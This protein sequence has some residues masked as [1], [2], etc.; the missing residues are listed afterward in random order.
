MKNFDQIREDIEAFKA[1]DKS[2]FAT[3]SFQTH[4][5]PLLHI[6]S[7]IDKNI[8]IF[9]LNT[10]YLFPATIAFKDRLSEDLGL[11]FI[12]LESAI[13]KSQ[14]KDSNGQLLF[15]SDP[16]YCC[17]LNK[18]Q[19][20]EPV[21]KQF[22]VWVNGIRAD[23]NANRAGMREIEQTPQGALRYHPMLKWNSRDIFEYR[24]ANRL[25]PHPME[26]RGYLSIGCEPCTRKTMDLNDDRNSR[27]FGMNKVECG[28]HTDL[29]K[30]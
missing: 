15:T 25:P 20:M 18:T 13:P 29:L 16:D 30:K 12:A 22:D 2:I 6:I 28:L 7:K 10:G 21:L 26:E 9:Y 24:K 5:I 17:A 3:S 23:Q 11:N 14:Q 1:Q 19:P 4:S 27:W 8:P